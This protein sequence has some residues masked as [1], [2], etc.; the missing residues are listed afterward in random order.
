MSKRRSNIVGCILLSLLILA[1]GYRR[2]SSSDSCHLCR[3]T[4]TQVTTFFGWI[5]LRSSTLTSNR[6]PIPRSHRHVWYHFSSTSLLG[7]R[8]WLSA[9]VA[10]SSR[11]YR[12]GKMPGDSQ[13]LRFAP[14][15]LEGTL[16][17]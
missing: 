11:M 9:R 13:P 14:Q 2:E 5:P 15:V 3:N 1:C 7:Y 10:C 16:T 4:R 17:R 12:D 8:G 6:Y